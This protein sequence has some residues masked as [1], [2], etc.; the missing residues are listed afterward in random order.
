MLLKISRDTNIKT[1]CVIFVLDVFWCITYTLKYMVSDFFF[2]LSM[3]KY[4]V[5]RVPVRSYFVGA[6]PV[7]K[8]RFVYVNMTMNILDLFALFRSYCLFAND[9]WKLYENRFQDIYFDHNRI[10]WC[11]SMIKKL[12]GGDINKTNYQK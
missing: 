11:W 6:H 5:S 9:R 7:A 4:F 2:L 1:F 8:L 3:S 12:N 10:Y